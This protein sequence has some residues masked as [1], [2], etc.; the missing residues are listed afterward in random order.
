VSAFF[1]WLL[2]EGRAQP[3]DKIADTPAHKLKLSPKH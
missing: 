2:I 3:L 1:A